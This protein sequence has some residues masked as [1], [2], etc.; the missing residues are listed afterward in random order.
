MLKIDKNF[1]IYFYYTFLKFGLD[2]SLKIKNYKKFVLDFEKVIKLKPEFRN[3]KWALIV[4]IESE[5]LWYQIITLRIT[6][7]RLSILILTLI[8][9]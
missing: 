4:I 3:K 5:I 1:K 6:F 7:T 2:F 8:S 9:L